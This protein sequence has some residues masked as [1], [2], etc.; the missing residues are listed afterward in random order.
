MVKERWAVPRERRGPPRRALLPR[1]LLDAH[2]AQR[3]ADIAQGRPRDAHERDLPGCARLG[4]RGAVRGAPLPLRGQL[5]PSASPTT[6][7]R[8]PCGRPAAVRRLDSSPARGRPSRSCWTSISVTATRA[9]AL[10]GRRRR[11]R[12][13][14]PALRPRGH[15]SRLRRPR[16]RRLA[17]GRRAQPTAL[18]HSASRPRQGRAGDASDH[19]RLRRRPRA[20]SP[21]SRSIILRFRRRLDAARAAELDAPVGDRHHRPAHRPA[22]PPRVPRGPRARAAARQPHRRSAR[23]RAARPR[24]PQGRQRQARPPGRRRAPPGARRRDPRHPARRRLR[25]PR[26]RRRVRDQLPDT[27]A[28]GAMEFA[29]RLRA[30]TQSA[31]TASRSPSPRASPRRSSSAPRTSWCARPTSR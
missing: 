4:R 12:R 2:P 22:Q 18:A 21:A 30:A 8:T 24:R 13:R 27:R 29:Q 28:Y 23:A 10:R 31:T 9:T 19:R 5:Q 20:C 3:R 25:L 26:R 15:R 17:P 1:R 14:R 6:P 7:P 16:G 11:R